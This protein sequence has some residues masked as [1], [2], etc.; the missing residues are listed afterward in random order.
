M[1][2]DVTSRTA[3]TR[4]VRAGMEL[5]LGSV[6]RPNPLVIAWRWRYEL[7]GALG[8]AIAIYTLTSAVGPWWALT[9]IALAGGSLSAWPTARRQAVVRAWC[10]ITPH[11]VRTGCAQAWIHSRQGK[12]PIVLFTT[13]QPFGERVYLWLRAGV[14]AE[15]L[16]AVRPLLAAA[17]WADDVYIARHDR[18]AHVIVLDVIRRSSA[19]P[20]GGDLLEIEPPSWPEAGIASRELAGSPP[21]CGPPQAYRRDHAWQ[22]TIGRLSACGTHGRRR[23]QPLAGPVP[24]PHDSEAAGPS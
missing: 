17:C 7:G 21:H 15:D 20:P 14:G 4:Q 11:R 19:R 23:H 12:I 9:V 24:L 3:R 10:I 22:R 13:A 18:Y 6:A 8:L 2:I 16:I 5:A 1:T